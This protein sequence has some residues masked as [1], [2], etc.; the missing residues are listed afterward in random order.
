MVKVREMRRRTPIMVEA[1]GTKV[2][3]ALWNTSLDILRR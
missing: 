3:E 1:V 2:P